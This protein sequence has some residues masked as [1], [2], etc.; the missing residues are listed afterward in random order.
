MVHL[1]TSLLRGWGGPRSKGCRSS[2]SVYDWVCVMPRQERPSKHL[3]KVK[4]R[5][6][7]VGKGKEL[8]ARLG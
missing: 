5:G 6:S 8:E 1:W 7:T 4:P 2:F 3:A